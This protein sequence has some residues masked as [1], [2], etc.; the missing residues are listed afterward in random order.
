M[1]FYSYDDFASVRLRSYD[2]IHQVFI[3]LEIDGDI[4]RPIGLIPFDL[5]QK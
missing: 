1:S 4:K 2:A 3:G 5:H